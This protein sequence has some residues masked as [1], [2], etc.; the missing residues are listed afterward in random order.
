MGFDVHT[1]HLGDLDTAQP[2][3]GERETVFLTRRCD[4]PH[5]ASLIA[6]GTGAMDS[7]PAS[8]V[9]GPT[10]RDRHVQPAPRV[11]APLAWVGLECLH[12]QKQRAGASAWPAEN[13]SA[14]LSV[15]RVC[16][17]GRAEG[18]FRPLEG[19]ALGSRV[20]S[21]RMPRDVETG[22]GEYLSCTLA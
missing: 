15:G 4:A 12:H 8:Q 7:H 9:L 21:V 10:P 20:A 1:T 16:S 11:S 2:A 22:R 17:R 18:A 19:F 3:L 13:R 14:I 5:A 6:V